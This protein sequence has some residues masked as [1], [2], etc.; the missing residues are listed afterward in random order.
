MPARRILAL[1]LPLIF[2]AF[3]FCQQKQRNK[4]DKEPPSQTLPVLKDP[5]AAAAADAA[6][7]TFHVS[8]LSAKGLL[9]QQTR[10]ALQALLRANHGAPMVK[11]RAFVA[12]TGDARRV[13]AIVSE[14]FTDKKQ[15]LPALSATAAV[16]AAAPATSA[17]RIVAA[18]PRPFDP[19]G[20]KSGL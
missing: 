5:P 16:Q 20:S 4:A 12:G 2:A 13:Q 6:R 17:L 15:P 10:D 7:L 11:L 19:S 1:T 3:A 14:I 9:T 8:P 18:R